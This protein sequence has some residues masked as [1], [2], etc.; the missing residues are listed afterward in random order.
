M[1]EEKFPFTCKVTK[2]YCAG[3]IKNIFLQIEE[4]IYF[5]IPI[6]ENVF[7]KINQ[8]TINKIENMI[9]KELKNNEQKRNKRKA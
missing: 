9:I 3:R 1:K 6:S 7:D 8:K 4:K 2:K 5:S